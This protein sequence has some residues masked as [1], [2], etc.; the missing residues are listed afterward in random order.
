MAAKRSEMPW[1][2]FLSNILVGLAMLLLGLCLLG[3][4]N[5]T[6]F[7]DISWASSD[8]YYTALWGFCP[9]A[10]VNASYSIS[11]CTSFL[12]A[13]VNPIPFDIRQLD[14]GK[15]VVEWVLHVLAFIVAL[16]SLI[17]AVTDSISMA[18]WYAASAS[19]INLIGTIVAGIDVISVIQNINANHAW[20]DSNANIGAGIFFSI[21]AFMTLAASA[22]VYRMEQMRIEKTDVEKKLKKVE[23]QLAKAT[24]PT[25]VRVVRL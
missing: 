9:T 19:V 3:G 12:G 7:K 4:L 10:A 11:E 21:L 13:P 1:R 17:L 23:E 14:I 2:Q 24:N 15:T 22:A 8:K 20:G 18:S 25:A 5:V 16:V 6:F